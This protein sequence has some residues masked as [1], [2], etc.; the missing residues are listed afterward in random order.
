[1]RSSSRV[2]LIVSLLVLATCVVS[3]CGSEDDK[4]KLPGEQQP[5]AGEGGEGGAGA[6]PVAG[7]GHAGTAGYGGTVNDAGQ[8]PIEQGGQ[9]GTPLSVPTAGAA[10]EGGAPVAEFHGLYIGVAGDDLGDGTPSDP[11]KTLEHAAS[12]AQFGDTIVFLDGTFA[13]AGTQ[14]IVIPAGVDL[15]AENAGQ[16]TLSGGTAASLLTLTG[17][18]RIS[19]LKFT[20]QQRV[21][22][23]A[24]AAIATVEDSTFTNCAYSCFVL[25]GET[26]LNVNG[27]QGAVLGNGGAAFAML[28]EAAS[29]RVTGGTLQNYGAGGIFRATQSASVS[30]SDVDVLDGTGLV[31]SLKNEAVA[32]VDGANV[33][34]KGQALF[35]QT[36]ASQLSVKGSDLSIMAGTP[37]QCFNLP[38]TA[39]LAIE[40][41]KVHGC[42][43]GIKGAVPEA[44]KLVDSEFYD[45][46][47]GGLD[48]DTG[49]GGNPGGVVTID[50]CSFHDVAYT[51][52]RLGGPATMLELTMRN[53]VVDVTTLANWN[54]VIL[55]GSNASVIDLGTLANPGNN[56]FLQHAATLAS[57]LAIQMQAV[58]VQ[59]VGNTW[60]AS[61]QGA[62]NAGHYAVKTGKTLDETSTTAGLN[63]TKPY[64]TSTLRLAQVP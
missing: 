1:M 47:F 61:V 6:A 8:P 32:V 45:L 10:G 23:F 9:G 18:T 3:A 5:T 55:N 53:T 26:L 2:G 64:A 25:S 31:L 29:I 37:Y 60:T 49:G 38:A 21:A 34:T 62:D 40:D 28:N 52:M 50:G 33:A 16:A 46:S 63:F 51:A 57:A 11:F 54:G 15:K 22:E 13:L 12:L 44:L 41:T 14:S 39:K 56:T 30:L 35:D 59:A 48:L 20:G 17:A 7:G 43:T 4:K 19:G 58:T 24:G 42:G 36:D 27:A